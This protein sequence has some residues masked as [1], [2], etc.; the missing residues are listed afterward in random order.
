MT[1]EGNGEQRTN[2]ISIAGAVAKQIKD[3]GR[4]AQ[5]SG[6]L[7]LFIAALRAVE[8]RLR[9]NPLAF[10]ELTGEAPDGALLYHTGS[11]WPISVRFAIDRSNA[12]VYIREVILSSV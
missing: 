2:E 6:R 5:Q 10:G 11:I 9:T 4:R 8:Q 7:K 3:E 12:V 1:A